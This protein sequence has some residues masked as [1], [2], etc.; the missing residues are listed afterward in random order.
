MNPVPVLEI[1]F[2]QQEIGNSHFT[3]QDFLISELFSFVKLSRNMSTPSDRC[4]IF[5]FFHFLR[6][7]TSSFLHMSSLYRL[8]HFFKINQHFEEFW[9]TFGVWVFGPSGEIFSE[10]FPSQISSKWRQI[11]IVPKEIPV[12]K[13]FNSPCTKLKRDFLRERSVFGIN[14]NS[15]ISTTFFLLVYLVN[16]PCFVFFLFAWLW[17]RKEPFAISLAN[18]F[19]YVAKW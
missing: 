10:A 9:K 17:A 5:A 11:I 7:F 6:H 18:I 4:P 16:L 8:R 19:P 1:Q 15:G 2:S 13:I 12:F 14:S 3:P